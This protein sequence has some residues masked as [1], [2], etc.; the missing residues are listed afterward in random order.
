MSDIHANYLADLG[1]LLRQQ[2][3]AA[4]DASVAASGTEDAA[5]ETGRVMAYHEV[6]SLVVSQ[7]EAFQLPLKDL[8]LDGFDPEGDLLRG[9]PTA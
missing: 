2:A 9:T 6:M 1:F 5:Y 4:R 3:I 7:A 8:R